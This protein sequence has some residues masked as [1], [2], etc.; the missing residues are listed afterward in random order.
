MESV[1]PR[2]DSTCL[3]CTCTGDFVPVVFLSAES[4]VPLPMFPAAELQT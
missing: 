1:S 2:V 4:A 3:Y